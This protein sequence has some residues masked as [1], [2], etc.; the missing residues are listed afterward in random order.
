MAAAAAADGD[1]RLGLDRVGALL[2]G[3]LADLVV[4]AQHCG[5]N[6]PSTFRA[7]SIR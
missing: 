5:A 7:A 6:S 3:Y 2:R 1:Y 4:L